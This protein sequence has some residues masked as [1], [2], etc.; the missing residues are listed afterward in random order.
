M[1]GRGSVRVPKF[2]IARH[3]IA[4]SRFAD[5][6]KLQNSNPILKFK[7][8]LIIGTM[9]LLASC[10][11][12]ENPTER[13]ERIIVGAVDSCRQLNE[14]STQ[15]QRDEAKELAQQ[16]IEYL[17]S[18]SAPD[19][20]E[21]LMSDLQLILDAIDTDDC[22]VLNG[23]LRFVI[24]D[25]ARELQEKSKQVEREEPEG[26]LSQEELEELPDFLREYE[27]AK[28]EC[29][30]GGGQWVKSQLWNGAEKYGYT[31]RCLPES[32][33]PPYDPRWEDRLLPYEISVTYSRDTYKEMGF[34]RLPL[35]EDSD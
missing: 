20:D 5:T 3:S 12:F 1:S 7:F 6:Y 24:S 11:L 18:N 30:D 26:P 28:Q 29:A 21:D 15:E 14:Q 27:K 31:L 9:C 17:A 10:Q 34:E 13:R 4:R 19:S 8:A 35:E 33:L 32:R 22:D 16:A 23:L 25:M 2:R